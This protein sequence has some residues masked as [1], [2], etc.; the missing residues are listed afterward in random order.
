MNKLLPRALVATLIAFLGVSVLGLVAVI[1]LIGFPSDPAKI[2]TF[3]SRAAPFMPTLDLIVGGIVLFASGWWAGRPF[4]RSLAV[5][6][7]L[8]VGV[9]YVAV[10][11]LIAVLRSGANG[12]D[13]QSSLLS[14]A[15][16]IVAALIGAALA[17]RATAVASDG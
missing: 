4:A 6:A 5:R 1:A 11:L 13:W 3:Q 15:V 12:I 16:K 9:G 17:G 8:I 14:Y 7:G 2:A 10:E